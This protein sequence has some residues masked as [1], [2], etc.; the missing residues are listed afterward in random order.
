MAPKVRR[1]KAKGQNGTPRVLIILPSAGDEI[2]DAITAEQF[3]AIVQEA[4][5]AIQDPRQA[6]RWDYAVNTAAGLM[7]FSLRATTR[8]YLLHGES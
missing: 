1:A 6:D 4:L 2:F 5:E 7:E 8:G 3:G